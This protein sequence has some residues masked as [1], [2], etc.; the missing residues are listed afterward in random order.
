[1][2]RFF[3]KLAALLLFAGAAMAQT[4]PQAVGVVVMHGKGGLPTR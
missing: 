1:M 2:L 3:S 4:A